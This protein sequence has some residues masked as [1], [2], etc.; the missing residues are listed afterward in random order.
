MKKRISLLLIAVMCLSLLTTFTSCSFKH[1]IT[2]FR[3]KVEKAGSC[4]I[5]VTMY[6]VPFFGTIQ[7][8]SKV[9][10]NIQYTPAILLG[11]EEY[12]ETVGDVKYK[13]TK[14]NSG[15]WIKE[16]DYDNSSDNDFLTEE[17]FNPDNYEKA[18]GE[19]NTYTQKSSVNF[20]EFED[21]KIIIADD[22]CTLEM[23]I[24]SEGMVVDAKVV[25]SKIGKINLTLPSVG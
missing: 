8:T 19:K 12:I 4:Q 17:L 25:I 5:D 7:A 24:I 20:D 23:K 10:G 6:N 2:D 11:E 21:V 1:P 22:S 14:N 15:K 16:I 13:Y 9:D 18:N 3:D